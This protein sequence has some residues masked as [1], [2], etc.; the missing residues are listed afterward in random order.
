MK[1]ILLIAL[2]ALTGFVNATTP[3]GDSKV[4]I[5]SVDVMAGDFLTKPNG[6]ALGPTVNTFPWLVKDLSATA[7]V[8]G[9][10]ASNTATAVTFTLAVPHNYKEGG[11]LFAIVKPAAADTTVKLQADLQ[12]QKRF[13]FSPTTVTAVTTGTESTALTAA[14]LDN[15]TYLKLP[16]TALD[17]LF[18]DQLLNVY[19]GRSSGTGANL[20]IHGFVFEYKSHYFTN[21]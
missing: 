12:V 4:F 20:F 3:E 21:R 10:I 2:M 8:L 7:L 5:R 14:A 1:K 19:V 15:L 11:R 17:N 16:N 18:G 9:D 13:A 6:T